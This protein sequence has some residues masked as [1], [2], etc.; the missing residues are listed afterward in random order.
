MKELKPKA[1]RLLQIPV[2]QNLN[3]F[4]A[5]TFLEIVSIRTFQEGEFIFHEGDTGDCLFVILEG[6]V[7]IVK[8]INTEYSKTLASFEPNT[9]FG[10]MTL[11]H[12]EI[13]PRSASALAQERTRLLMVFKE[14]FQKLIDFGSIIAYK[15]TL[16]I[17]RLLSERLKKADQEL[18]DL[19]NR[20]DNATKEALKEFEARRKAIFSATNDFS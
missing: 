13:S 19:I 1:E 4:E 2:F 6:K 5:Q 18:I 15:V 7:D 8:E 9:A 3:I 11:I 20:A 14:D 10:E 16:N 17:C 12:E